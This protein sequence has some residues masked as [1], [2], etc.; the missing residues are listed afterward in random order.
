[1]KKIL[2]LCAVLTLV[3]SQLFAYWVVLKDGSRYETTGKPT[4]SGNK[5]TFTLKNGQTVQVTADAIDAAKSEEATRLGGGTV[6]G[7][8][9]RPAPAAKAPSSL[10]SQIRLRRQ[11][12]AAA[13]ANA[14][15]AP[16][17][18]PPPAAASLL[19]GEVLDKFERAYENVGIF[20]H[21]MTATPGRGLRADLTTDS[22]DKVFNA[23]SATAFLIVHNAGLSGV[24]IDEVHMFMKMTNGGTAGRFHMTRADAQALYVGGTSPD[25]NRLQ[26]Y[27]I[28]KVL[29]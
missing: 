20:E 9:Q 14:G 18:A 13:A 21:K 12:Q 22:E 7:V 25:K 2:M 26:E 1:M 19:G 15:T 3:S 8:E 11:Q 23:I 28:K 6:L 24:V 29:F 17:V 27:F 5:A 4:I 10:G 16:V